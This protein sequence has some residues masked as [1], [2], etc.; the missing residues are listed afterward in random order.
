MSTVRDILGE[1]RRPSRLVAMAFV[2]ATANHLGAPVERV[3][4]SAARDAYAG[5]REKQRV[6]AAKVACQVGHTQAT[7]SG[8]E[9]KV[10]LA[11]DRCRQIDP[12]YGR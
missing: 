1:L 10:A 11:L 4:P 2:V 12:A 6:H 5:V 9:H 8:V 3:V 7:Q